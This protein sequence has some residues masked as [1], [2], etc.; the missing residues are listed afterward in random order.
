M[1]RAA[2]PFT[3][4]RTPGNEPA[5]DL[6]HATAALLGSCENSA[7]LVQTPP[8]SDGVAEC[9]QMQQELTDQSLTPTQT[10]E[11][12]R[13]MEQADSGGRG[14]NQDRGTPRVNCK[15]EV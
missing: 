1:M 6:A 5:K 11:I 15:E 8:Q 9:R 2:C 12:T 7:R 13:N 10:A 4:K 3:M 14:L